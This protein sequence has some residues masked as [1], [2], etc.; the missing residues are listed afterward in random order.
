MQF[1]Y[2]LILALQAFQVMQA[3]A[4]PTLAT[5]EALSLIERDNSVLLVDKLSGERSG[6]SSPPLDPV[7]KRSIGDTTI[8]IDIDTR[9]TTEISAT[10]P[11][12]SVSTIDKRATNL[13]HFTVLADTGTTYPLTLNGRQIL[14]HAFFNL[15]TNLFTLYWTL[16]TTDHNGAA[17]SSVFFGLDDHS[18]GRQVVARSWARG[19][20]WTWANA[21]LGNIIEIFQ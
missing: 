13:G 6:L 8:E 4:S 18:I 9:E 15:A 7:L 10:D 21:K 12:T 5:V 14:I 1:Q 3:A 16:D 2:S 17:P 11:G 20:R 19:G